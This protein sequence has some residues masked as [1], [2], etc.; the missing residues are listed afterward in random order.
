MIFDGQYWGWPSQV[1]VGQMLY[2][3]TDMFSEVGLSKAPATLPELMDAARKLTKRQG[4]QITRGGYAVRYFGERG[5]LLD[6]F[7]PFAW[8]YTDATVGWVWNQDYTDVLYNQPQYLDALKFY[9]D[10]VHKEKVASI[11]FPKPVEAFSLGLAAMTNRESFMIGHLKDNAPNINFAVAPLVNGAP[12]Y[13]KYEV[14]Y[15]ASAG[16]MM[17]VTSKKYPEI[18]WDF[19]MFLNNKENDL[20]LAQVQGTLPGWSTNLQSDYVQNEVPYGKIADVY[21]KRPTPRIE[22]DPW[23]IGHEVNEAF[24]EGVEMALIGQKTPEKAMEEAIQKGRSIIS[25]VNK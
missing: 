4:D 23:G 17:M 14:G 19:S 24:A 21:A 6:K 13:G 2:Y 11:Q 5:G 16:Q 12:P 18:A 7:K 3:N 10:M 8:C 9:A 20:R 15:S 22:V 1:D 25:R